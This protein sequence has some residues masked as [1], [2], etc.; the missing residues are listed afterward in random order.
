MNRRTIR[1]KQRSGLTFDNPVGKELHRIRRKYRALKSCNPPPRRKHLGKLSG[2]IPWISGQGKVVA[3]RQHSPNDSLHI[4][5]N[6]FRLNPGIRHPCHSVRPVKLGRST[7]GSQPG[8]KAAGRYRVKHQINSTPLTKSAKRRAITPARYLPEFR[9][10]RGRGDTNTFKCQ[11]ITPHRVIV[12]RSENN[13][14][15]GDSIIKPASIKQ[16][17]T[18]KTA[19]EQGPADPLLVRMSLSP[20]PNLGHDLLNRLTGTNSRTL[21]FQAT[22]ERVSVPITK[23]RHEESAIE[24]NRLHR[25]RRLTLHTVRLLPCC[26]TKRAHSTVS[27][28]KCIA[29]R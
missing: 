23:A 13:G 26:V 12:P 16:A 6:V 8:I 17:F 29:R 3:H 2:E 5:I 22:Q 4:H 24:I 27:H 28:K 15:I 11:R 10:R 20:P 9:I 7:Q 25:T 1:F 19:V 21:C 14:A 18:G